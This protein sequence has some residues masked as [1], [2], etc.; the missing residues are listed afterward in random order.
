MKTL[1]DW[2]TRNPMGVLVFLMM[3]GFIVMAVKA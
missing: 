1:I 3:I 2:L